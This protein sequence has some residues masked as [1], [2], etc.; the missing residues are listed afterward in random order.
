MDTA[1]ESLKTTVKLITKTS[2]QKTHTVLNN[3][4]KVESEA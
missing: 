2:Q 1:T 4:V 3:T